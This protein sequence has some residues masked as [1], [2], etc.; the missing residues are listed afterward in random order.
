MKEYEID[1]NTFIGGWYVPEDVCDSVV[2][3]FNL[4]KHKITPSYFIPIKKETIK[5]NPK[6]LNEV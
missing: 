4:E 1:H 6:P 5:H 2:D 3:V